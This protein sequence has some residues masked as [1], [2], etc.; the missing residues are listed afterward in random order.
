MRNTAVLLKK[1]ER[2]LETAV[3]YSYDQSGEIRERDFTIPWTLYVGLTD[4]LESFINLPVTWRQQEDLSQGNYSKNHQVGLGDVS[5][6]LNYL[7]A[8]ENKQWPDVIGI[9]GVTVPTGDEPNML[10]PNKASLG[11]G[12]WDI[13]TGLTLIKTYDPAVLYGGIDYTHTFPHTFNDGVRVSPGDSVSYWFGMGFAINDQLALFSQFIGLF[14]RETHY[15]DVK[16]LGSAQEQ[17]S[18]TTGFTY[19]L[20]K[21]NYL[22]PALTFGLNDDA[23][24]VIFDVSY[25]R[26]F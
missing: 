23:L 5:V 12:H 24:D 14:Q 19:S 18:L 2:E 25:I 17:M 20:G 13:T 22:Q 3:S 6:G 21:Y 7:L 8:S 16:I 1:G 11:S 10:A 9:F 26:R 15:D 4:R